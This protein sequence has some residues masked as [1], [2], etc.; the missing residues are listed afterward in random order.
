MPKNKNNLTIQQQNFV[1]KYL[2]TNNASEA[3]RFAYKSKNMKERT[4]VNNAYK[5]LKN[6]DIA[7]T[8]KNSQERLQTKTDITKERILKELNAILEA[9]ITDYVEFKGQSLT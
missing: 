4:I 5:L 7:T 2:E 8:I 9:K 6:N 1:D 3:Y